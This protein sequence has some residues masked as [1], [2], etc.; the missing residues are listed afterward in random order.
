MSSPTYKNAL[1]SVSDKT[2]LVELV[3]PLAKAGT[4]IVSTGG[5]AD[6]LRASGIPVVNV[7]DWTGSPEV[8][9]GRVKTLHPRI[10]M[11]LLARSDKAGDMDL[12]RAEDLEPFDLVVVNLYPFEKSPEIENI[13]IGGPTLLRAASKSFER[14]TVLSDPTDYGWV[15]EKGKT[16][17][18]ERRRLAAKAFSHVSVYDSLVAKWLYGDEEPHGEWSVG[19]RIHQDLRYGENPQQKAAWLR[20]AGADEGLHCSEVLQ[21]KPLSYNN[22]LDLDAAVRCLRSFAHTTACVA[23]KHNNPCGVGQ[24]E[25]LLQAT[26]HALAADPKSVFGGIIALTGQV[27]EAVAQALT[28]L[29]LECVVAPDYTDAALSVFAKKAN[30]RILRWRDLLNLKDTVSVRSVTGGLLVQDL[31]VVP[32]V[33]NDQ[34]RI[35]GATPDARVKEDLLFAWK[36]CAHLKSNAI[37][38]AGGGQSRG[39]GMGQVNRVDA[40]Q[41]AISRAREF[42]GDDMKSGDFVLASDAFFPFPDSVDLIADAGIRWVIQPGGSVKDKEVLR[43]AQERDVTMVLTGVRHFIH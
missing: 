37:A 43:R 24:G 5:T 21:G 4:R 15:L 41:Q 14:L 29:F 23:V 35:H 34:W 40:V 31:D 38:V 30:L 3:A 2:G 32:K 18:N 27:D 36:V 39:F 12:L 25:T 33:W 20:R 7:S 1:V 8:M 17:L 9:D 11:A 42:H 26:G 28:G 10:H 16:D 6:L 13:D 19:G 22:I